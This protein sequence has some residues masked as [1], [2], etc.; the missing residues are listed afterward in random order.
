MTDDELRALWR[1]AGG[2]F[3][4]PNVETGTMPEAK[5]LPLLRRL[6]QEREKVDS[7]DMCLEAV[8]LARQTLAD[9]FGGNLAFLDDDLIRGVVKMH[10]ELEAVYD[11]L[12]SHYYMDPPDGGDVPLLE[13][14][15]RMAEDAK[16]WRAHKAMEASND[17]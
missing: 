13:Q 2:D 16:L 5:L 8:T 6:A 4:G 1:E 10:E 17:R 15:R 3:H 7:A 12:P 11:L 9:H 14:M